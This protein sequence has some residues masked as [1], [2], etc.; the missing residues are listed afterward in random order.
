MRI[1]GAMVVMVLL[2]AC[3]G[4]DG[5]A[6]R[7]LSDPATQEQAGLDALQSAKPAMASALGAATGTFGGR[8]LSCD[9][10]NHTFEYVVTGGVTGDA[11]S[12]G[13]G[14]DALRSELADAGWEL[15]DT[16]EE[17]S[18]GATREGLDLL[19]QRGRR[20]DDG[21]EWRLTLT[22]PCV[23]FSDADTDEARLRGTVDL[24]GDL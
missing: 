15:T 7:D 18:V 2:T 22:A 6:G 11:A 24:S 8:H 12:W 5:R 19:V 14:T 3:S 20:T 16:V 4:G 17:T 9:L 21:V 13:G 23:A 1:L 10:G